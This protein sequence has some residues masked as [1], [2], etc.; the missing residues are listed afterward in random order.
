[1]AKRSD[2]CR[3]HSISLPKRTM[4]YKTGIRSRRNLEAESS[5]GYNAT[6]KCT[7]ATVLRTY[8]IF[9]SEKD[10][11]LED[12]PP[13]QKKAQRN[14]KLCHTKRCSTINNARYLTFD[15]EDGDGIGRF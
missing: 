7:R 11:A 15:I 9:I 1:M 14:L 2:Q 12:W 5:I 6:P 13:V 3:Q 4:V 10:D 8:M